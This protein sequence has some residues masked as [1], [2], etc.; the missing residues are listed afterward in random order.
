MRI[1]GGEYRGR[2]VRVPK[3]RLDIRPSMDRMRESIFA[4]LGDLGGLS[5]LD[6]FSGTGIIGLEAAS[7]GAAP[8]VCVEKDPAKR[9]ILIANAG[10]SEERI[11][12]RIMPVELFVSRCR[13]SFDLAFCDPPFP[14]RFRLDLVHKISSAGLLKPDG[15]LLLHRPSEDPM[16]ERV[17]S[18][19]LEDRRSYGRSIVDIYRFGEGGI[20]SEIEG[21]EVVQEPPAQ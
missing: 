11:E 5:F 12:C 6:L 21:E 3:G 19:R 16:P 2:T 14:Y 4:V 9:E 10:I 13:D 7:R 8:V 15:R 1:T 17:D 18:L 20:G